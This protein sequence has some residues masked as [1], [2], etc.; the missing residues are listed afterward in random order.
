MSANA[1]SAVL[2]HID[3]EL[4]ASLD[5]LFALLRIQSISTDPAYTVQCRNA[6]EYVAADLGSLGFDAGLRPTAGHPVVIG[7]SQNGANRQGP[8][9]LFYGHYDVQPVDPLDLWQTPPFE[10]RIATID[11]S[12]TMIPLPCANTSVLAVPRSMARSV[13]NQLKID[14]VFMSVLL[15]LERSELGAKAKDCLGLGGVS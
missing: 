15:V 8:H 10:P 5:R 4:D 7:K 13:E 3:R 2:A 1:L 12:F 11:G 14:R 6:A 9:V